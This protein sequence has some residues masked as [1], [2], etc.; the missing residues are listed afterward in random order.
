MFFLEERDMGQRFDILGVE[1][2]C[3]K[4]VELGDFEVSTK[5]ARTTISA[6]EEQWTILVVSKHVK[7]R[8]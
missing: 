1:G 2:Y 3:G 5:N 4:V 8:R 7:R 6:K